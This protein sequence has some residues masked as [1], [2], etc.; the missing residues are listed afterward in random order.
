MISCREICKLYFWCNDI[1]LF[2]PYDFYNALKSTFATDVVGCL[3][4]LEAS[5]FGFAPG[6]KNHRAGPGRAPP[7]IPSHMPGPST[8]YA[9]GFWARRRPSI[10][11]FPSPMAMIEVDPVAP[12]RRAPIIA[13]GFRHV[14]IGHVQR[15]NGRRGGSAAHWFACL[16]RTGWVD[17]RIARCCLSESTDD[18]DAC[19]RVLSPF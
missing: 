2:S 1:T 15:R 18:G 4:Q 8:H 19:C 6:P 5:N 14:P 13:G 7:P 10:A 12:A 3:C 16:R 9:H 17:V 11:V